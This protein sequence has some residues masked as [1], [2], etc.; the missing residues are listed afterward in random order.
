MALELIEALAS[1]NKKSYL[2]KKILFFGTPTIFTS[3]LSLIVIINRGWGKN[4]NTPAHKTM[5]WSLF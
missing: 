4:K 2:S 5:R 1:Y 3:E